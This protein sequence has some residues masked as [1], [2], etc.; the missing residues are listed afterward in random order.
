MINPNQNNGIEYMINE[1]LERKVSF[2]EG[3]DFAV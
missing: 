3:Y 1:M 2:L